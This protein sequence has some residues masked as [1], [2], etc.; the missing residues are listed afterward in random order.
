VRLTL[1]RR[2]AVPAF[3]FAPVASLFLDPVDSDLCAFLEEVHAL[4]QEFPSLVDAV[5][6][7]LDAHGLRKKAVR[8]ADAEWVASRTP[9]LPG[10]PKPAHASDNP[11]VLR[12]GRPRTPGYV[13]L[14]AL[15]LRGY[16]GAGF[17]S[18]DVT[19]AC[20]TVR[21]RRETATAATPNEPS[22]AAA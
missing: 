9:R 3:P 4:I 2:P 11:L 20:V 8:A 7:D 10:M 15:L 1:D 12:D 5:E 14:V 18:A 22:Q 6:K 17:K 21:L 13:V 19:C 16:S